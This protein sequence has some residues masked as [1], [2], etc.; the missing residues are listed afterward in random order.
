MRRPA[1]PPLLAL[2]LVLVMVP[3]STPTPASGLT[4][5]PSFELV[6]YPNRTSTVLYNLT[7]L[8]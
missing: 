1:V 5:P 7:D 8:E 4:V 6:D 3:L 2:L